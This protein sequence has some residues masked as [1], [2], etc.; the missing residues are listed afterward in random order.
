MK[1]IN[2]FGV[3]ELNATEKRTNNGGHVP[4]S[5]YLNDDV[6]KQNWEMLKTAAP[7]YKDLFFFVL[8]KL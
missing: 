2:K 6:I 1:Q 8:G 4:A 3:K 5:Y 7:L